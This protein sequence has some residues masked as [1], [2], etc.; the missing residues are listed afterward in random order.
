MELEDSFPHSQEPATCPC[1][2]PD[3]SSLISCCFLKT[4]FNITFPSGLCLQSGFL[5]SGFPTK[6]LY[7]FLFSPTRATCPTHL[8]LLGT[9]VQY[10]S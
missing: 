3:E 9:S 8:M 2:V 6:I 10:T 5:P 4:H 7:V 1:P